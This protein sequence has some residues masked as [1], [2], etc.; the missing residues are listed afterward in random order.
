MSEQNLALESNGETA[1]AHRTSPRFLAVS[2]AFL[3]V[4]LLA[5]MAVILGARAIS[6]HFL[7][8]G[9]AEVKQHRFKDAIT[10]FTIAIRINPRDVCAYLDRAVAYEDSGDAHRAL[11]DYSQAVNLQPDDAA[12]CLQ[13]RSQ[14]PQ[15][16]ADCSPASSP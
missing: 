6:T 7:T 3:L 16:L 14:Y 10:D 2:V 11:A 1:E 9:D 15:A 13:C 4:E 8:R 12:A 5:G